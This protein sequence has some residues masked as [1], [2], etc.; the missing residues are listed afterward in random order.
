MD[1][2]NTSRT[3]NR[4]ERSSVA[5]PDGTKIGYKTIGKGPGIIVV[6]GVLSDSEDLTKLADALS[7]S[8][9]LHLM[10][11]RG[12][13]ESGPQGT[14]YSIQKECEDVKAIQK[15]TNAN[16]LIGHSF[17][18]LV[19]L[20]LARLDHTFQKLALYDPGLSIGSKDWGWM[21][22]YQ[23]ALEDNELRDAF[24]IFVRGLGHTSL[25]RLPKW[26]AKLILGVMVQGERWAKMAPL[27]KE[28]LYEHMETK[29]LEGTHENYH[30]VSADVLFL[31]GTK[32]PAEFRR[33]VHVLQRVITNSQSVFIPK[34]DHFGPNNEGAP[35]EV[36]S[37]LRQFFMGPASTNEL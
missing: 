4:L 32:S 26:Y 12:R 30:N 28:N 36:A 18:G 31:S 35:I 5:S 8:F 19:G 21:D 13:G 15:R 17:G 24:T 29:R 3:K 14:E 23:R 25:T 1:A 11:R 20:E 2:R 9:T 7:D 6:H 27:L 22:N 16:Y 37:H 10:D 34:L 33:A